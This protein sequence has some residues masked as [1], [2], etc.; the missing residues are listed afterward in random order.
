MGD[1]RLMAGFAHLSS[2]MGN[3]V[4]NPSGTNPGEIETYLRGPAW[5]L[6]D[7]SPMWGFPDLRGQDLIVPGAIGRRP[8]VRRIDE[9]TY[10]MPFRIVGE[11]TASG[12]AT[13][14]PANPL[15]GLRANLDYLFENV[16]TPP[17]SGTT[18]TAKLLLP[19]AMPLEDEIHIAISLGAQTI[20]DI[21]ALVSVTVPGGRFG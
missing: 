17:S 4:I 3:L 9:T 12:S 19:S 15:Q 6:L 1:E 14:T 20:A 16:H 21:K 13:A 11:I 18:R 5:W 10:V 7:M 8:N 2:R